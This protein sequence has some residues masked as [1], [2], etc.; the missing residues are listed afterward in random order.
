MEKTR[1]L[2]IIE[3]CFN[4]DF[5]EHIEYAEKCV[6][7][8]LNRGE[9]PFHPHLFYSSV[10]GPEKRQLRTEAGRELEKYSKILA[11]YTDLDYSGNMF[12]AIER[13]KKQG[14]SIEYRSLNKN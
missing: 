6:K 9:S 8:S 10:L 5:K 12:E 14:R 7:D 4:R 1:R 3:S 13:A 2:V 11:I